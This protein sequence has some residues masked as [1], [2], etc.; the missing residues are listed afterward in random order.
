MRPPLAIV[1]PTASGKSG[2]AV[3]LAQQVEG[4]E[5][6][7]AD[8]KA[9]YRRMDVG[10]AKP[11]VEERAGISH[12][13]ID[14]VEPSEEYD[15][16]RFVAEVRSALVDIEA[17][18]GT[19]IMV[20]GT[21][22]YVQAIVDELELP[23]QFPEVRAELEAKY[24][25][26][27]LDRTKRQSAGLEDAVTM[28][29]WQELK[30]LDPVGAG[31]MEPNNRR[32]VVRALEVCLGSGRP[33]SSFG[34]G[35]DAYPPSVFAQAG[36][37]I[38][39]G[40]MDERIAARYREQ[41]AA[42]FVDEVASL[43]A[44]VEPLSKTA[45]QSLGYRELADHLQGESTLDEAIELANQRTKRFARRQQRWFRRDPRIEWFDASAPDLVD[46]VGIWWGEQ[47]R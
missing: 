46:R 11:S 1:G 36:L 12:H 22:L 7:S 6:I 35:M 32:R 45:L 43:L 24:D 37:E 4:A 29:L 8:A 38:D 27:D 17:R 44:E 25:H 20:G 2:L 39:R 47:S 34:P 19:A 26:D 18:D 13:L 28:R 3:A 10:T 23:G 33:F 40:V 14:V 9:V 15:M 31:K 41:L 16:S 30:E 5:I 21:G 42:G